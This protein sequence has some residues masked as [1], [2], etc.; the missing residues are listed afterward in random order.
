MNVLCRSIIRLQRAQ[1]E[2]AIRR[3]TLGRH[4]SAILQ[5]VTKKL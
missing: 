1:A 3:V 5:T 2:A 4:F